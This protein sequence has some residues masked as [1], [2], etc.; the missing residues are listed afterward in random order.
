MKSALTRRGRASY[1]RPIVPAPPIA[2]NVLKNAQ[3]VSVAI[4][5]CC[6]IS[7]S[8]AGGVRIS[9]GLHLPLSIGDIISSDAC[10]SA[11]RIRAITARN[12][13]GYCFSTYAG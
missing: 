9:P 3:P 11:V 4:F 8:I 7:F 6:S 1:H 12:S 2:S 13:S 5:S 10:G